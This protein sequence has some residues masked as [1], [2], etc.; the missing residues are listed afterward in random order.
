[1]GDA[2]YEYVTTLNCYAERISNLTYKLP[3]DD[4]DMIN[5]LI[6]TKIR[7]LCSP[8]VFTKSK[9]FEII[10]SEIYST[11]SSALKRCIQGQYRAA[12]MYEQSITWGVINS[13]S[14]DAN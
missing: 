2:S 7:M 8:S 13:Q 4:V 5:G 1:M 11:Q 3:A 9:R 12:R 14:E 6:L 10:H